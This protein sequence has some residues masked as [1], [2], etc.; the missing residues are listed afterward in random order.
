ML[1]TKFPPNIK[2]K[3]LLG[4]IR[5]IHPFIIKKNPIHLL[6]SSNIEKIPLLYINKT[7][8]LQLM[9]GSYKD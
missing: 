2:K 7:R 5:Y 6:F 8:L 4:T 3:P 9:K 1:M